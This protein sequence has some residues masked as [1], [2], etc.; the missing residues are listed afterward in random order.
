MNFYN[1][2]MNL[3]VTINNTIK[4]ISSSA[5]LLADPYQLAV[6]IYN[7]PYNATFAAYINTF[8][9]Q[10]VRYQSPDGYFSTP[11]DRL[12][13]SYTAWNSYGNDRLVETTA[14]AILALKNVN[15][16]LYADNISRA[17]QWLRG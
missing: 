17:Y 3:T 16:T 7:L 14:Y 5:P 12:N 9:S 6:G 15:R 4:N 13:Y 2:L 1:D 8:A 11:S 10:L